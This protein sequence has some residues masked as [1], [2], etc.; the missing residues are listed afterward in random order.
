[1]ISQDIRN[2]IISQFSFLAEGKNDKQQQKDQKIIKQ[3]VGTDQ[4]KNTESQELGFKED[5]EEK[6]K[7]IH[8]NISR[9]SRR[10]GEFENYQINR[11]F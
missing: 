11:Q 9:G 2:E 8:E 5:H 10:R 1:M 4:R 6:L 3:L 7:E